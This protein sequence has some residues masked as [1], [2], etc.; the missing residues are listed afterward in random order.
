MSRDMM[1]EMMAQHP[2]SKDAFDLTE[3]AAAEVGVPQDESIPTYDLSSTETETPP[4]EKT[5]MEE[6]TKSTPAEETAAPAGIETFATGAIEEK[7]PAPKPREA[8]VT[9]GGVSAGPLNLP[10][11]LI[12]KLAREVAGHVATHIVQELKSDLLDR[13]ERILWEVVPEL[14][15]QLITQEIKRIRELVEGKK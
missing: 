3:P 10:P 5:M 11:E 14:G 4:L 13:V 2:P 6:V 8:Q 15:E 12:D 7:A 1:E 9:E